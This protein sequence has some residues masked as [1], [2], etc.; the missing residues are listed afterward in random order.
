M[1]YKKKSKWAIALILGLSFV[2][3]GCAAGSKTTENSDSVSSDHTVDIQGNAGD[4]QDNTE[5][6]QDKA[7]IKNIFGTVQIGDNVTVDQ[8]NNDISLSGLTLDG[9]GKKDDSLEVVTQLDNNSTPVENILKVILG[10]N[11]ELEKV[12]E[13]NWSKTIYTADLLSDGTEEIVLLLRDRAS[14]YGASELHVLKIQNDNLEEILTIV[15]EPGALSAQQKDKYETSLFLIPWPKD[16]FKLSDNYAQDYV[17]I[18]TDGSLI[19]INMDGTTK[20]GI[21]ISHFG[22]QS[23]LDA[24]RSMYGRKLYPYSVIVWD[25]NEWTVTEQEVDDFCIK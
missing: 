24:Y 10:D 25:G 11:R 22:G 9:Q 12:Y 19:D 7:A 14:D 17:S 21:K 6:T 8:T 4:V 18:C 2:L 3:T 5:S 23:Q 1:N 16:N 20:K 15:D 13:G